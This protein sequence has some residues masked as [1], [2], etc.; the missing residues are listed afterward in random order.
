MRKDSLLHNIRE[1]IQDMCYIW[2]REMRST[3][4]DEGVLIFFILVP[5]LY[6]L[7]Y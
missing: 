4:K 3:V 6:A 5:R 2:A 7:L 1:G